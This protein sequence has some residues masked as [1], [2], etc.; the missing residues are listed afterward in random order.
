MRRTFADVLKS[1]H[2]DIK[3]E[4]EKLYG[5][6]F[7]DNIEDGY[8]ESY[9][10]HDLIAENFS[11]YSISGTCLTLEEFDQ[12]YG[13]IFE[14]NPED[15][16]IDYLV[17][18][19][20]YIQNLLICFRTDPL[21]MLG[22]T[23][24]HV[25]SSRIMEHIEK[26]MDSIGYMQTYDD[27]FLIYVEKS[28]AAIAVSESPIIPEN[29]SYRVFEYNH[30]SLRGDIDKKKQILIAIAALLEAKRDDLKAAN[31][32]LCSDVFYA[33]NNLNLR[34]NNIDSSIP[35]KYKLTVANMS[36]E[37]L[38]E[39]YDEVFQMCLLAILE[40]ENNARKQRFKTLKDSIEN[41]II[42]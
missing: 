20:E 10:L 33:F 5:I 13:F 19:C 39:W 6:M 22:S 14:E 11:N 26:V 9:S 24:Q 42:V 1:G 21:N 7:E 16:D 3:N 30:H 35:A 17:S 34:H 23:T 2:I 41:N 38:E 28:P 36:N 8:D 27:A 29:L 15:F 40:I 18:F 32:A 12:K 4:Y 31:S 25:D 37:K